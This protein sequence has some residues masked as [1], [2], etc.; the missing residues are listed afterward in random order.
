MMK[1]QKG[2]QLA[3]KAT[4]VT[5]GNLGG[6]LQQKLKDLTI[7]KAIEK[8]LIT[9][10]GDEDNNFFRKH[11]TLEGVKY[12]IINGSRVTCSE[13]L[14]KLNPEEVREILGDLKFTS[15]IV[16]DKDP[17]TGK[18]NPPERAGKEWFRLGLNGN[19][20]TVT[21]EDVTLNEETFA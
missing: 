16:P 12:A 2:Q 7:N 6:E 14:A 8:G 18:P 20:R 15:G 10:L 4:G 17:Q 9:S 11:E 21:C 1:I 3:S 19:V 13:A 5:Y